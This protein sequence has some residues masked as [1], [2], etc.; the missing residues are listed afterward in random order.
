MLMVTK[1]RNTH[2]IVVVQDFR[3]KVR[4]IRELTMAVALEQEV[5]RSDNVNGDDGAR[6]ERCHE[7]FKRIQEILPTSC[8]I[9][10]LKLREEGGSS[11]GETREIR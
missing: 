4:N 10:I 9:V 11:S 7:L 3:Y 6:S 2:L 8:C 1:Y 5:Q